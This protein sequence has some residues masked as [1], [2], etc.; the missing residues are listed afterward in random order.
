[1]KAL[2]IAAASE[3]ERDYRVHR[4]LS[5]CAR[6]KARLNYEADQQKALYDLNLIY[7]ARHRKP[8]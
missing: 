5:R 1:M 2:L 6:E 7:N 3:L 8:E 4:I